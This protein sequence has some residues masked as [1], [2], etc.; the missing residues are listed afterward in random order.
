MKLECK[1]C[2][3]TSNDSSLF[4]LGENGICNFC[5][6][7]E[8]RWKERG[9]KE[10]RDAELKELLSDIK[11]EKGKYNCLVGLS[12]GVDSSYLAFWAKENNLKPLVVHLDNGWNS[13]LAV[14]NIHTI[15]EKLGYDLKTIVINWN[16]FKNLQLAYLKAG[17]VDI[18]VLTDHAIYAT[19]AKLAKQNGIKFI[20][21]GHNLATEAIMPKDWVYRKTDWT[22]IKDIVTQYGD[23]STIK[24]F[25]YV[26]FTSNLKNHYFNKLITCYPLNLMDYNKDEVKKLLIEKLGW[27]DYGGKHYESIFTRF[28]Q[29]YILPKKFGIDKR[30]AHLSTLINSGQ[31]IKEQALEELKQDL[32]NPKDLELDKAYVLKK[33]DLFEKEFDKMMNGKIRRH[34]EFKTDAQKWENYFSLVKKLKFWKTKK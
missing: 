26:S 29:A 11:N 4:K 18:E 14:Q 23:I 12:G 21:S 8:L 24:T 9:G 22:N 31:I 27:I 13:E 16:E 28:Y 10:K 19:V 15:C 7:F 30:K 20:L 3:L 34:E 25:P 5:T 6:S 1:R 2:V 33:L 17:V 32:Y